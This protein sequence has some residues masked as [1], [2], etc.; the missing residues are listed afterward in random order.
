VNDLL[1]SGNQSLRQ[2]AVSYNTQNQTESMMESQNRTEIQNVE[3]RFETTMNDE[4]KIKQNPNDTMIN[5]NSKKVSDKIVPLKKYPKYLF[6]QQ[7]K[8]HSN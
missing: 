5:E 4:T 8:K 7:T 3:N 2:E 6:I 1:E